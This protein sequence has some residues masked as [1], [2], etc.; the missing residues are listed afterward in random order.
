MAE[1]KAA[2]TTKEVAGEAKAISIELIKKLKELRLGFH[3]ILKRTMEIK[4]F[5]MYIGKDR[6]IKINAVNSL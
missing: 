3:D 5:I 2:K 6:N 4:M 1:K